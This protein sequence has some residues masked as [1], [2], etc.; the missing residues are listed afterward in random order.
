MFAATFTVWELKKD[1]AVNTQQLLNLTIYLIIGS[2]Q[3][4]LSAECSLRLFITQWN[5]INERHFQKGFLGLFAQIGSE[6]FVFR[7]NLQTEPSLGDAFY[8]NDDGGGGVSGGLESATI[9]R[10][11][12]LS[13]ID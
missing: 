7:K 10:E 13:E 5:H 3:S 12:N 6:E 9:S 4:H 1:I 2:V 11:I 8:I